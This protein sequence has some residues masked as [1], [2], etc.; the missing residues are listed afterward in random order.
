[1]D[2]IVLENYRIGLPDEV[3]IAWDMKSVAWMAYEG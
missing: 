1:M 3:L 2:T